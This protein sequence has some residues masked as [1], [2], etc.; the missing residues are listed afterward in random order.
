MRYSSVLLAAVAALFATTPAFA[1]P[2]LVSATPR[3]NAVVTAPTTLKLIFSERLVP[4]FSGADLVMTAMPGMKMGK[5]MTI[6]GLTS[7]VSRDGRSVDI[8]LAKPL[9][10]GSYRLTYH[11]VST[12]THRVAGGYAFNVK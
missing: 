12:D 5:P 10:R 7:S 6:A 2:R 8:R 9:S 3:A 11:V 4:Q 1:H